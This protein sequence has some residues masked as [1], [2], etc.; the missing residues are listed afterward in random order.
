MYFLMVFQEMLVMM[1]F[2][3]FCKDGVKLKSFKFLRSLKEI[4]SQVQLNFILF[5]KL[6]IVY[7]IQENTH[8]IKIE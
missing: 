7:K 4:I 3:N 5:N 1:I 6:K 2:I 8:F